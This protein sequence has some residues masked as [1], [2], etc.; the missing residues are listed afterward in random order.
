MNFKI[1]QCSLY[2]MPSVDYIIFELSFL[3]VDPQ[4]TFYRCVFSHV[5]EDAALN[6]LA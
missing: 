1:V 5:T 4:V 2:N 6:Q 3:V